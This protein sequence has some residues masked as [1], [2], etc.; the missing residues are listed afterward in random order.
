MQYRIQTAQDMERRAR[1]T[2][3]IED[4]VLHGYHTIHVDQ[5]LEVEARPGQ[6]GHGEEGFRQVTGIHLI[7]HLKFNSTVNCADVTERQE[8]A[9]RLHSCPRTRVHGG[10]VH[11]FD[12]AQDTF[13]PRAPFG[14]PTIQFHQLLWPIAHPCASERLPR[15]SLLRQ[16]GR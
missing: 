4:T 9:N 15:D 5:G 3:R 16:N 13:Y 1:V 11:R 2:Q 7:I 10:G 14:Q 12:P 8:C 6:E